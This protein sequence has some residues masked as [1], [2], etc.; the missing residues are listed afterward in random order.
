MDG[1]RAVM[2]QWEGSHGRKRMRSTIRRLT[3][4]EATYYDNG[5][6]WWSITRVAIIE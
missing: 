3:T 1:E 4:K 2:I 5:F 6:V